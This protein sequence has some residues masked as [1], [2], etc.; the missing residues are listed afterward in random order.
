MG[1]LMLI[2]RLN[3][4][5]GELLFQ[6]GGTSAA[7][8]SDAIERTDLP[9][10]PAHL[11]RP[12]WNDTLVDWVEGIDALRQAKHREIKVAFDNHLATGLTSSVLGT[13]HRYPCARENQQNLMGLRL[14]NAG[15]D[16]TCDDTLGNADSVQPRAHT[17]Q[18]ISDLYA[19]GLLFVQ[20]AIA[21]LRTKRAAIAAASTADDIAAIAW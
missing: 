7:L 4:T 1:A 16:Y 20:A 8:P 6:G 19:E 9:E 3:V 14:V 15:A 5:T 21:N 12:H 2:T 11:K 10:A 13:P 17:P 18:Q